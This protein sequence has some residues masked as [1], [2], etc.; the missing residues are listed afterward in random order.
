MVNKASLAPPAR[1]MFHGLAG[2]DLVFLFAAS[3]LIIAIIAFVLR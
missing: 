1:P 2:V 3:L